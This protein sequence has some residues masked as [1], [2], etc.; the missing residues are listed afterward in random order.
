[1]SD[2]APGNIQL[3]PV[4]LLS[5]EQPVFDPGHNLFDAALDLRVEFA[6]CGFLQCR[7]NP[8]AELQQFLARLLPSAEIIGAQLS[9]K[10][11]HCFVSRRLDKDISTKGRDSECK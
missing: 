8:V 5:E 6:A 4:F 9:D 3:A 11:R 10:F 7:Q 1:M 2:A